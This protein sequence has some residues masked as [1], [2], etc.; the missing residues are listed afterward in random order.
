[1]SAA[2]IVMRSPFLTAK[3]ELEPGAAVVVEIVAPLLE[4]A[5]PNS[6]VSVGNFRAAKTPAKN[7]CIKIA[8]D[9]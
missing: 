7:T 6:S 5:R 8:P 1:M 4:I 3:L 2:L 9:V